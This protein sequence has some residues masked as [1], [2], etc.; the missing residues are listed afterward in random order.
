VTPRELSRRA[1]AGL[2]LAARGGTPS[3]VLALASVVVSELGCACAG[4][5]PTPYCGESGGTAGITDS[6]SEIV[7]DVGSGG[8]G[9]VPEDSAG[10]G[11]G[12]VDSASEA[13]DVQSQ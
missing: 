8:S 5:C 12:V 1:G 13:D 6:G 10:D 7:L 3:R 4:E 2:L 11:N 9:G